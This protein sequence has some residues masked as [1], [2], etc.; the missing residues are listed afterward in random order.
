MLC[1][2]FNVSQ[3]GYYRH[4]RQTPS[5]R[6]RRRA[7]I[8]QRVKQIF[9]IHHRRYGRPRIHQELKNQSIQLSEQTLYSIMKQ[10]GLKARKKTGYRPKTTHT[11]ALS[12]YPANLLKELTP[13]TTN[14]VIVTDITYLAT[15]EN[16]LYLSAVMDL[17]SKTIKGYCLHDK[18]DVNGPLKALNRAVKRYPGLRGAIH[19]SDRGCQYTSHRYQKMLHLHRLK[20]SM[21]AQ[22]YCYDNAAMESFWATLKTECVP[23]TGVFADKEEARQAVF[24]YIEGYYNPIRIHSALEYSTPLA[25]EA[26]CAKTSHS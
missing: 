3:S 2:L 16:W 24:E 14:Q 19:H 6:A 4:H 25:V 17:Y 22:G 7:Q 21:S 26:L 10:H 9:N 11:G 18:L 8:S 23:S 1:S 13:T 20:C 5:P 15:K 12:T